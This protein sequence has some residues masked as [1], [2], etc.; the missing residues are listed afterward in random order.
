MLPKKKI[1]SAIWRKAYEDQNVDVGISCGLVKRG[2]IGKG[3]WAAPDA[4]K[5]ML[6]TKA[7]HPLAGATCAWVRS[8]PVFPRQALS[9]NHTHRLLLVRRY[10]HRLVPH[11][12]QFIIIK[13]LYK[14]KKTSQR[15][16][17]IKQFR[18]RYLGLK[19]PYI[20]I[21]QLQI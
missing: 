13:F 10:P 20:Y 6:A 11:F 16:Y 19:L 14:M 8:P 15:S 12:M 21:F 17:T 9:S 4:M 3:M 5:N 2:Q 7:E 18:A 1:K